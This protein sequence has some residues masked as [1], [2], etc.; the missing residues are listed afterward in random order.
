MS[1][2]IQGSLF[3]DRRLAH[4]VEVLRDSGDDAGGAGRQ[5]I[6][7]QKVGEQLFVFQLRQQQRR[8]RQTQLEREGVGARFLVRDRTRSETF[9]GTVNATAEHTN[10]AR[11][12]R[13]G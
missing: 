5:L 9:P 1:A 10:P 13:L 12:L 3:F 4:L 6:S 2:P 11:V 7:R 8:A